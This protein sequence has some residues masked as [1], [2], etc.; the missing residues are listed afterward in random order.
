M[1]TTDINECDEGLDGCHQIC[2]NT[3]GSF[4]CSCSPGFELLSDGT[5]CNGKYLEHSKKW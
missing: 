3:N 5:T 2:T 1:F 4:D